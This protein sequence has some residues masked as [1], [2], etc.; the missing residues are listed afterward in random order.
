METMDDNRTFSDEFKKLLSIYKEEDKKKVFSQDLIYAFLGILEGADTITIKGDP[1]AIHKFFYNLKKKHEDD[2]PLLSEFFFHFIEGEPY[3]DC[4]LI[5]KTLSG[6]N[7][8]GEPILQNLN[9]TFKKINIA[10]KNIQKF[11]RALEKFD[12]KEQKLIRSF[13]AEFNEKIKSN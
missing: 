10:S 12:D 9:P 6:L 13:T 5:T 8:S 4:E 1:A 3:P 7:L 11:S 2:L